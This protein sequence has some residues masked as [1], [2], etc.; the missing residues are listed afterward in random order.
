MA[1]SICL[2]LLIA[3]SGLEPASPI[4][5][6]F[7]GTYALETMGISERNATDIVVSGT[8]GYLTTD[9]SVEIIDLSDIQHPEG[10]SSVD[11]P[12]GIDDFN[13]KMFKA[14]NVLLVC[15]F[16]EDVAIIN[17]ED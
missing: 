14:G 3:M 10:L 5:V 15:M 7:V 9:F 16:G 13:E 2:L 12:R 1:K 4:E 8:T 6:E 17:V 11:L